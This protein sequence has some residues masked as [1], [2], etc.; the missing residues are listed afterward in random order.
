MECSKAKL[1][2]TIN[3]CILKNEKSKTSNL[4]FQF[5]KLEKRE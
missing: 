1:K 2:G 3:T 4:T 5:K